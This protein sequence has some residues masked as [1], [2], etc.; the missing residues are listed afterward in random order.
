VTAGPTGT[1]VS[2]AG[3]QPVGA[4]EV[5][6]AGK[7]RRPYLHQIDVVRLLTFVCVIGVH[8][9]PMTT[10]PES[11]GAG[12][13]VVLLHFTRNAFF[14]LSAFVLFHVY[15]RGKRLQVGSFWR[16]RFFFIGVPYVVWN[17]IY[18]WIY[19]GALPP[20]GTL[21][22]LGLALVAGTGEYHL[23][24]LLVSMQ[25]YLLFPALLWL[26]RRTAGH[27]LALFVISL[28]VELGLMA[29]HHFV[30]WPGGLGVLQAHDYVLSPMYEFYF[31]AGGLAAFHLDRFHAW[32]VDHP[33][34]VAGFVVGT[35][36]VHEGAYLAQLATTGSAG[37]ADDP[38][39]P[40]IVPWSL[41]VTVGFYAL[42]CAYARSRRDGSRRARFVDQAS[43]A[44][45][46]VY[47]VHPLFLN[48]LLGRW[49]SWGA[50]PVPP[51]AASAL[52]WIGTLLLSYAFAAVVIRTPLA[53]PLTGRRRLRPAPAGA[54]A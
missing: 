21:R 4:D 53:L 15:A 13:L 33:G 48:V 1:A 37:I 10:D 28:A 30:V 39:Q 18:W 7:P 52:A 38:L 31:L 44:S 47:L 42:G 20:A 34:A 8:S 51:A 35:G 45:F 40:S 41:A 22:D 50:T 14:L 9:I 6:P 2:D 27:H 24:F 17:V 5:R 46:G 54:A 16:H 43:L 29:L 32:V 19:A 26:V 49:L 36:V 3:E 25:L 23:Y 12:G 11:G